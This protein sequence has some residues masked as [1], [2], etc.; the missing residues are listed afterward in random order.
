MSPY[1]QLEV[2]VLHLSRSLG[3]QRDRHATRD[4]DG[5]WRH[6]EGAY[7]E[8]PVGVGSFRTEIN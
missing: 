6:V 5:V 8:R 2:H 1:R 3:S 4:F 7:V